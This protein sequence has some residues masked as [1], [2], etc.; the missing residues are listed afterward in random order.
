MQ[1]CCLYQ[2]YLK[3]SEDLRICLSFCSPVHSENLHTAG[4]LVVCA[5]LDL[6]STAWCCV[7]QTSAWNKM[8]DAIFIISV[9]GETHALLHTKCNWWLL[10]ALS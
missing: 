5:L 6:E 8:K 9:I 7:K 2:L 1:F 10:V 3:N 4:C